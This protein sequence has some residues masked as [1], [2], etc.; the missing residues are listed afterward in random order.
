MDKEKIGKAL[1]KL[2]GYALAIAVRW[3]IM[4]FIGLP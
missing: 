3:A 4:Y 2:I 1:L